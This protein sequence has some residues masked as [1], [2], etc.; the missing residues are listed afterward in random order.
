MPAWE[1]LYNRKKCTAQEA[2]RKIKSGDRIF[3][4]RLRTAAVAGG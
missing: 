2:I 3:M 4:E 1:E